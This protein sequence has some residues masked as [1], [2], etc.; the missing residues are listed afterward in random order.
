MALHATPGADS[1]QRIRGMMERQ[2]DYLT[3]LIDDLMDISRINNG[4]VELQR[5]V[6]PIADVIGAAVETSLPHIEA[7]RHELTIHPAG[8]AWQVDADPTRLAQVLS[9]ILTNAAKY[10]PPGGR[11]EVRSAREHDEVVVTISDNGVGI[12]PEAQAAVFD[13]FTQASVSSGRAQGGLG[14]GLALVKRLVELHGGS[15]GV[16][17]AGAGQ[18][19]SF[20]VRLPAFVADS[21]DGADD[22]A[23]YAAASGVRDA[24]PVASRRIL[25]AD[26]N[27]DAAELLATTLRLQGHIVQVAN[28]GEAALALALA[29]RPEVAFL[30]LGMPKKDG[31]QLAREL[32]QLPRQDQLVLIAVSGWGGAADRALSRQAG[33]DCHLTKRSARPIWRGRCARRRRHSGGLRRHAVFRRHQRNPDFKHRAA[34]FA[35][36]QFDRAA[37]HFIDDVVRDVQAQAA[38]ALSQPR[39]EEGLEHV[40]LHLRRD[41]LAVVAHRERD[42][43]PV[44]DEPRRQR[45]R[46]VLAGVVE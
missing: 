29:L 45:D 6:L 40:R 9:N 15:V 33:F 24:A 28:D 26:D 3:H 22:A 44:I 12:L 18:G 10:T 37:Q 1:Q 14:I 32:R 11:I 17:S 19:A 5:K 4:K 8:A 39:R 21:A 16:V 31:F 20:S 43:L 46:A 42:A 34:A 25:V 2:V 41:A 38:A 27:V 7:A 13:M 23:L 30:D 36:G 35:A